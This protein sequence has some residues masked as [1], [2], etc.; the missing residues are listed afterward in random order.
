MKFPPILRI[1]MHIKSNIA[2][3]LS[4][5]EFLQGV[6]QFAHMWYW[7]WATQITLLHFFVL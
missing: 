7:C 5:K 6:F 1:L 3:Y 4:I 2:P